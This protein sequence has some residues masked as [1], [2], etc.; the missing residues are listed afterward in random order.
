MMTIDEM[1]AVL[2]A[3]KEGKVIEYRTSGYDAGWHEITGVYEWNFGDYDYRVKPLTKPSIN[4]D[5]VHPDYKWMMTDCDGTCYLFETKPTHKVT[6]GVVW[7]GGKMADA[8]SH[9]SFIAGEC[10]WEDSLVKRP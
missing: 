1:L 8:D 6:G 2:Q 3:H 5:Y 9:L 4:W 10:N 7:M